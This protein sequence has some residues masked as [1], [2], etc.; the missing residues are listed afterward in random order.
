MLLPS[1]RSRSSRLRR[2][3]AQVGTY[4]V[5]VFKQ[6]RLLTRRKCLAEHKRLLYITAV[7]LATQRGQR[8]GNATVSN[9]LT[10]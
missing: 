1:A 2:Q 3:S 4:V 8:W 9:R 5:Q 6:R 7:G 10:D